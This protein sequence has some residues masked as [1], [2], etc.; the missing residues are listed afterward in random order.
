[1]HKVSP[2][3]A[4]GGG[5][6]LDQKSQ[7]VCDAE[8]LMDHLQNTLVSIEEENLHS[9]KKITTNSRSILQSQSQV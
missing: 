8:K 7:T 5:D 1:M 2:A 6:V 9:N 3:K 4:S